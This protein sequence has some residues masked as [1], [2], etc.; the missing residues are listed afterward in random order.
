LASLARRTYQP[1]LDAMLRFRRRLVLDSPIADGGQLLGEIAAAGRDVAA[2]IVDELP[3]SA[4]EVA[5]R[6]EQVL[7]PACR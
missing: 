3:Q 4:D 2:G 7:R 6:I 5:E 1:V